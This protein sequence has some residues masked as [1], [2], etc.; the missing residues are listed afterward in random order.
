MRK[1]TT[2]SLFFCLLSAS[3]LSMACT[4]PG[5]KLTYKKGELYYTGNVTEADAKKVGEYFLKVGYFVDEEEHA[6]QLDKAGDTYQVRMVVKEGIDKEEK[7]VPM[8]REVANE[9][10]KD[11]LGGSKVEVHL[12]DSKLKTL[13]VIPMV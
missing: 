10:S 8:F 3:L 12:T 11:L 1:I 2:L 13:K 7:Y 5:T 4:N 6:V 9:I